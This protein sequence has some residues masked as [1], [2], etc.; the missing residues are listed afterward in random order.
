MPKDS[1]IIDPEDA[2]ESAGLVYVTDDMPGISRV[3]AGKGFSYRDTQGRTIRDKTM[4]ARLAALAVP[5][6]YTDVWICPDPRGHIQATGR[7][8]RGRKQYRYHPDFRE[9][10]DSAKYDHMLDFAAA[11]PKIRAQVA[12]DMALRGLPPDKVLA[13]VVWLLEN[14]MIRV[15]NTGYAK[16]NR[17]HGLTTLRGRHVTLDGSTVRFRFRGKGGKQWDLGVRDRRIAR[18]LRAVQDLPGQ[19]L[20]QYLDAEGQTCRVDSGDVNAYLRRVSGREVTAKDFRTWTG[21]VLAAMA[22][23][24]YEAADSEAAANANVRDAI[25]TVAAK[26]GNTPAICRK[27]YVHPQIIDAYL[28]DELKLE[29]RDRIEDDLKSPGLRPEERQ[30]LKF[31]RK[32]LK[33]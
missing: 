7:D 14:T 13:T 18:I 33:T 31:L 9:V 2:A 25:E 1:P 10:R 16:E 8:A 15:G 30:V 22:L 4:R 23:A 21:T 5:P 6:A 24:E 27:C 20:F 19:Q 11:L 29:L 32:R 17:S 26:L 3:R 28:A 12:T